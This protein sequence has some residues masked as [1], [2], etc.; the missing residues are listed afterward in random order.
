MH[1]IL[2]LVLLPATQVLQGDLGLLSSPFPVLWEELSAVGDSA[3]PS[4]LFLGQ[5]CQGMLPGTPASIRSTSRHRPTRG[6]REPHALLGQG[7][8]SLEGAATTTLP[9][10]GTCSAVP[11]RKELSTTLSQFG[12]FLAKKVQVLV[13]G[14]KHAA[15]LMNVLFISRVSC[16]KYQRG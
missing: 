3:G 12:V 8:L 13:C 1:L 14:S 15:C 16:W 2:L 7:W 11:K 5:C 6:T 4:L 10:T 9:R